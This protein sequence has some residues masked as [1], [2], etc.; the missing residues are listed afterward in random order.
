MALACLI[1]SSI[2]SISDEAH[3]A[4]Q[5]LGAAGRVVAHGAVEPGRATVP[6]P[7]AGGAQAAAEPRV[8]PD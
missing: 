7:G 2:G 6:G 1:W 5:D 8:G 4:G 3:A